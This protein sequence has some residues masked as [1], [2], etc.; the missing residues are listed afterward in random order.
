MRISLL[1]VAGGLAIVVVSFFVTNYILEA[2]NTPARRDAQRVEDIKKVREAVRSYRKAR[3]TFPTDLKLLVDARYLDAIP[4]D[5]L[6]AGTPKRYQY[7]S[8]GTNNFGLLVWLEEQ[9]GNVAAGKSCRTGV[10]AK[11]TAMWGADTAD[12]PF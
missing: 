4:T 8:D 12:C 9:Q 5:P 2:R 10:G 7:Y 3:G 11:E 6:W 1:K